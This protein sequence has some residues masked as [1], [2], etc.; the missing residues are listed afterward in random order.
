MPARRLIYDRLALLMPDWKERH[1]PD[2]GVTLVEALAYAGDH[3]SYYQDA[4]A[5]EAYL[6]T[7]RKRI[8]L[9][10][11]A[12]LVDYFIHEGSNARAFVFV[13]TSSDLALDAEEV[14]FLTRFEDAPPYGTVIS[15]QHLQGL[16]SDSYTVFEPLYQ[17]QVLLYLAHNRI[18]LYTWGDSE[19]CLPRG[20]TR[21]TLLDEWQGVTPPEQPAP[22]AVYAEGP[23]SEPRSFTPGW[24]ISALRG[25]HWP[26]TGNPADAAH[27]RH[28][29]PGA[30]I[31]GIATVECRV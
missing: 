7:A 10:R 20:A 26:E 28:I 3:L 13:E 2:L 12:R 16:P 21:A 22:T 19:C 4:V 15:P 25:G 1:V 29:V 9:R 11:H 31:G 8:S 27:R 17:A 18:R 5:T 30:P 23:R 14:A 24:A 6:E